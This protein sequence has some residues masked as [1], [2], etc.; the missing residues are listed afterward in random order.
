MPNACGRLRAG[1]DCPSCDRSFR[2]Q[3]S[4]RKIFPVPFDCRTYLIK[5]L[6]CQHCAQS[7]GHHPGGTAPVLHQHCDRSV[8]NDRP[9][10]PRSQR[11]LRRRHSR[12]NVEI[13]S[14][15]GN[16]WKP[17]SITANTVHFAGNPSLGYLRRVVAIGGFSSAVSSTPD[18]ARDL[19]AIKSTI[20]DNLLPGRVNPRS[21]KITASPTTQPTW[22]ST[23]RRT[24]KTM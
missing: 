18:W 1:A 13:F 23:G 2:K 7:G 22:R 17:D 12:R 20:G 24:A 3:V 6:R 10:I 19:P 15:A 14:D 21:S 11:C 9:K 16:S 4:D 8:G 5:M